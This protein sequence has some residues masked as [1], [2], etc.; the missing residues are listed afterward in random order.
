MTLSIDERRIAEIV[1]KVVADLRPP[2]VVASAPPATAASTNGTGPL[3]P[4]ASGGQDGVYPDIDNALAAARTA[5]ERLGELPLER[6]NLL[7]AA[8]RKAAAENA[9]VLARA[10]WQETGMGRYEDK[11]EKNLL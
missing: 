6:R 10:A 2:A 9:P 1:Q 4:A 11:V 5:Q 3:P 8:M 7:I